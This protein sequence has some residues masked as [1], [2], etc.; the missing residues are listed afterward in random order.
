MIVSG[1][2][3]QTVARLP[4]PDANCLV[5]G[6]TQNPRQV[7][8][9]KFDRPHI[10]QV[11]TQRV[12]DMLEIPDLDFIIISAACKHTSRGMKI[13][14]ADRAIVFFEP[15]QQCSNPIVP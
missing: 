6:T 8:R 12:Q 4:I 9:M 10:I 1:E 7:V 13:N 14:C 2:D 5:I 11:S 15:I 3:G